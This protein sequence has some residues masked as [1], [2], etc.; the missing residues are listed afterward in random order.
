MRRTDLINA[1]RTVSGAIELSGLKRAFRQLLERP[2]EETKDRPNNELIKA[3]NN[4]SIEASKFGEIERKVIS[5]LGVE[6]A[7]DATTWVDFSVRSPLAHEFYM[8]LENTT[9]LL[10]KIMDL[11][12]QDHVEVMRHDPVNAPPAFQGKALLSVIIIE[13]EGKYSNPNRVIETLEAVQLLYESVSIMQEQRN[14]QQMILLACDSGSDKSFDLLG[15]AKLVEAVKEIIL[16]LWDRVVFFREQKIGARL[17]LIASSLPIIEKISEMEKAGHLEREQAEILRRKVSCGA[18]K[19]I[20]AG[21]II[22]EIANHSSYNP[23]QLM[24]PSPKLL[25]MPPP[26]PTQSS[27]PPPT[28]PLPTDET[29]DEDRAEFERLF[30]QL[31]QTKKKRKRIEKPPSDTTP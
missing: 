18:E 9:T 27:E 20:N 4:F 30:K 19:F 1:V 7:L 11:I 12:E 26:G 8:N 14:E 5:I 21:A 6:K 17:E 3:L 31:K 23:R 24:A 22:P 29:D 13:E 15:I 28:P 10:P 2:R 25:A 16:S